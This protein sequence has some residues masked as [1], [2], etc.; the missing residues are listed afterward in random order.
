MKNRLIET[1]PPRRE[2]IIGRVMNGKDYDK[3][4]TFE[5]NGVEVTNPN[6]DETGRFFVLPEEY[7]GDG[8]TQDYGAFKYAQIEE[9]LFA[10]GI[11]CENQSCEN[12]LCMS[13]SI[14]LKNGQL[15][16]YVPNSLR[17]EY[18]NELFNTYTV[19]ID[20]YSKGMTL[21]TSE[22]GEESLEK[23]VDLIVRTVK[24]FR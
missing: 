1:D 2:T 24:K 9:I 6:L 8:Y 22:E 14:A 21:L 12:D 23:V 19:E 16:V 15:N 7:Y 10:K 5:F 4:F 3:D 11:E 18:D 17:Q 13:F 20:R